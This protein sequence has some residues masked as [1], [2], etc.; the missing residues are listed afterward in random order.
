MMQWKLGL[1]WLKGVKIRME[2]DMSDME[3]GVRIVAHIGM[4]GGN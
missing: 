3:G 4:R 1:S 2:I